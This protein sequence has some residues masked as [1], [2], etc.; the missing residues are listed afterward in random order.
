MDNLT[1]V[2][3]DS[4]R[5]CCWFSSSEMGFFF[6]MLLTQPIPWAATLNIYRV[7]PTSLKKNYMIHF[8]D[9]NFQ[10]L[11]GFLFSVLSSDREIAW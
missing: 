5:L 11:N 1:L 4:T 9:P 3:G 10:L 6:N 2:I 7:P 8:K